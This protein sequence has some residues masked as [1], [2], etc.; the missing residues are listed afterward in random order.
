MYALIWLMVL[1][2]QASQ[3]ESES[4]VKTAED[5]ELLKAVPTRAIALVVIFRIIQQFSDIST[6]ALCSMYSKKKK[7]KA[8]PVTSLGGQ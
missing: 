2:L 4:C 3:Q 6:V 7:S 8:I 1:L 5:D